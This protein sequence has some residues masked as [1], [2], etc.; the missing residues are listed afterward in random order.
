MVPGKKTIP[1]VFVEST[2]GIIPERRLR[3][4]IAREACWEVAPSASIASIC[5]RPSCISSASRLSA[6][7][8]AVI[9]FPITMP[10]TGTR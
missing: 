1:V 2:S 9:E 6:T 3:A 4:T 5:R 7:A 8:T 10:P